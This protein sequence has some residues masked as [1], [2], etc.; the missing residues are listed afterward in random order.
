V[1]LTVD[2]RFTYTDES[3]QQHTDSRTT[4]TSFT[5]GAAQTYSTSDTTTNQGSLSLGAKLGGEYGTKG[6]KVTGEISTSAS[7]GR[8]YTT[9]VSQQSSEAPQEGFQDSVS[10][11]LTF[12]ER[13][14]V[15]RTAEG[16]ELSLDV[17]IGNV[18]DL[19]FIITHLELSVLASSAELIGALRPTLWQVCVPARLASI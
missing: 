9:S 1:S 5:Q 4:S 18:S 15:T 8:E 10:S 3:S 6:A 16:A 13:R 7:V 14:A 11:S 17:S 12:S 2:E 19:A